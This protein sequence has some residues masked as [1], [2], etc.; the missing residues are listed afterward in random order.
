MKVGHTVQACVDF[1]KH[2]I[3]VV[4]PRREQCEFIL[5]FACSIHNNSVKEHL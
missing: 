1:E 2:T 3:H 4:T 5:V